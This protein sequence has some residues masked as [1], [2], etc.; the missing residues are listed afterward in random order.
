MEAHAMAN[1]SPAPEP[2]VVVSGRGEERVHNG[3]PWIYR[4]DVVD[5]RATGGDTVVVHNP[6]GRTVGRALFS[7]RSQIALRMLTVGEAPAGPDLWRSRLA[8]AIAF[9]RSLAID[10]TACRLVHGEGDLLPSCVVDQYGDY[11]VVQALS[12]GVDRLLPQIADMLAR[13]VNPA[14]ILAR[15][16]AKVRQLEGLESSVVPLYGEVPPTVSVREG[17]IEHEVDLWHGQKTGLFLDQREN[18]AAARAYA[19]GRLL[20]CFSY[21]GAFAL[22]LADRCDSAIALEISEDAVARISRNA[23]RNGITTID[24]RHANVF[25]ALRQMERAHER[26][27]TI[28]LDPP[29]F[30]KSKDAV[31]KA[32]AGYKE[33]NLRAMKLLAAGGTLVTCTCSYHVDEAAF[34]QIVYEASIDARTRMSVLEKRMQSRDH[35]VVLGVPETYYLKCFILRKLA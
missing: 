27:D 8:T 13:L 7:D 4:T 17:R 18:R 35:P 6:R 20:D 26:F 34:G 21:H 15:N 11:L 28:V 1:A 22:Q 30:A 5:V 14:A 19:R 12:Q 3:H 2:K 31:E 24:A 32:H 25:D 23:S 16:D 33:I 10:A 29:A 9:R